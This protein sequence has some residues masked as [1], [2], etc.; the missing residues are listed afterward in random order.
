MCITRG[1]HPI[2]L[3]SVRICIPD[4]AHPNFRRECSFLVRS[5]L[6]PGEKRALPLRHISV[7]GKVLPR[8]H[9]L[10]RNGNV[11]LLGTKICLPGNED[12]PYWEME[13]YFNGHAR[14]RWEWEVTHWNSKSAAFPGMGMCLTKMVT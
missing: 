14:P 9:I 12:L 8:M 2:P 5:V 13:M 4:E 3:F 6:I 7:P 10:T 1:S 11:H